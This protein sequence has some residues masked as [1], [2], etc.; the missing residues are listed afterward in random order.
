MQPP[1]SSSLGALLPPPIANIAHAANLNR[2]LFG[3]TCR[4]DAV[5]SLIGLY[6]SLQSVQRYSHRLPGRKSPCHL[7]SHSL[8]PHCPDLTLF[9]TFAD[10][11][12]ENTWGPLISQL[13]QTARPTSCSPDEG[14]KCP[15]WRFPTTCKCMCVRQALN[16]LNFVLDSI[17][18]NDSSNA[19]CLWLIKQTC[20]LGHL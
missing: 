8:G 13:W 9:T 3:F 2:L 5:I 16:S 15:L 18:S 4:I 19:N 20:Q 10:F 17:N 1:R 12:T 6:P 7:S 11:S 14:T